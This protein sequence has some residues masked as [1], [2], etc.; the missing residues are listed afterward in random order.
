MNKS[1]VLKLIRNHPTVRQCIGTSDSVNNLVDV[2]EKGRSED[3]VSLPLPAGMLSSTSG[4]FFTMAYLN[5]DLQTPIIPGNGVF[6][7]EKNS[8]I[9]DL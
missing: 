4:D 5:G 8:T 9:I 2:N 3:F 6:Y 1:D 7:Q